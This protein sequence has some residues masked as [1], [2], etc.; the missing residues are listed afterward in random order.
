MIVF[1][2]IPY[3]FFLSGHFLKGYGLFSGIRSNNEINKLSMNSNT[4]IMMKPA[5][6]LRLF[7][8][9]KY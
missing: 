1:C 5:G 7:E 2:L 9:Y 6:Y 4:W 3:C 8:C